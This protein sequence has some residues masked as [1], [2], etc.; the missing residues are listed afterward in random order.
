MGGDNQSTLPADKPSKGD[1]L[2]ADDEILDMAQAKQKD[3]R[4]KKDKANKTPKKKPPEKPKKSQSQNIRQHLNK[5]E[6]H[7][8]ADDEGL[9]A[10][11]PVADWFGMKRRLNQMETVEYVDAAN[12][13]CITFRPSIEDGK[14]DLSIHIESITVSDRFTQVLELTGK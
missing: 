4:R 11:I 10:A 12:K 6:C 14:L 13:T 3:K 5:N 9:K 8:H 2:P 1:L 7:W